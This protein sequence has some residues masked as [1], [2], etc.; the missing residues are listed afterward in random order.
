ML[1]FPITPEM[2]ADGCWGV[3]PVQPH[4]RRSV[5]PPRLSWAERWLCYPP[6]LGCGH[7]RLC[8]SETYAFAEFADAPISFGLQPR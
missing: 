2:P 6:G 3:V 1:R 8:V 4:A 5:F 7:G